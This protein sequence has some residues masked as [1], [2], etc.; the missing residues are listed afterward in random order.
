MLDYCEID[1]NNNYGETIKIKW[2]LLFYGKFYK[3]NEE[4][5]KQYFYSDDQMCKYK[6]EQ[7]DI[8]HNFDKLIEGFSWGFESDFYIKLN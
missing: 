3:L 6:S 5:K 1:F 2:E 7:F 4:M 8:L